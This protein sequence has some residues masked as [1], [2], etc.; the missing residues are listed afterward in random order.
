MSGAPCCCSDILSI[1]FSHHQLA[2]FPLSFKVCPLHHIYV[3]IV[4]PYR[5]MIALTPSPH[6]VPLLD[7]MADDCRY[8]SPYIPPPHSTERIFLH[9]Q[10]AINSVNHGICPLYPPYISAPC[11][12]AFCSPMAG[13]CPAADAC[14]LWSAYTNSECHPTG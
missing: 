3:I 6:A 4:V 8:L 10:I 11:C 9:I 1:V 2:R 12:L 14:F 5:P 13:S 7:Q